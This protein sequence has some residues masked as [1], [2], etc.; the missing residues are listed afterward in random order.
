MEISCLVA[1]VL[2]VSSNILGA[3]VTSK[4][5][6]R[7]SSTYEFSFEDWKELDPAYIE[8]Q[9]EYRLS[10]VGLANFASIIKALSLLGVF[11]PILQVSWILSNG[12][13]RR[14]ASHAA[15]CVLALAGGLCELFVNLMM[16]GVRSAVSWLVTDF[17]M[18][19]WNEEGDGTGWRVLEIVYL[20]V[21]GMYVLLLV[22]IA[23]VLLR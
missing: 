23:F 1:L 7:S 2:V 8:R 20:T 22:L 10:H 13:K 21:R 9:F 14:V 19:D 4:T 12:G 3:I 15:I 18:D 6:L 11:V 17:N 5:Y 16:I